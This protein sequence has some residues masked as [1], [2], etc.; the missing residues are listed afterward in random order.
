MNVQIKWPV[1]I[2]EALVWNGRF[3]LP[4]VHKGRPSNLSTL[5]ASV[6]Q[7]DTAFQQYF[8]HF[9]QGIFYPPSTEHDD[10]QRTGWN[11]LHISMAASF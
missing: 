7:P 11:L 5:W 2:C 3:S 9:G 4:P 1:G 8:T 6:L 10:Q